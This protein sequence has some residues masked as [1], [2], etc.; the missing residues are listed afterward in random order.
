MWAC[1]RYGFVDVTETVSRTQYGFL[2]KK[3]VLCRLLPVPEIY[4][5]G[6]HLLPQARLPEPRARAPSASGKMRAMAKPRET[7]IE[8][9][10]T[11]ELKIDWP[12]KT[13]LLGRD[14]E[15]MSQT[16]TNCEYS[17]SLQQKYCWIGREALHFAHCAVQIRNAA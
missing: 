13:G 17:I 6:Y 7:C 1:L 16:G 3:V 5:N 14:C 4:K 9:V 10:F 2:R 15:A 12:I 11:C 8:E